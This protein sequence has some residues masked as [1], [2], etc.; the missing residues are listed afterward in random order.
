MTKVYFVGA[1][2]GAV[3]LITVRGMNLIK[4]ADVIIYAGSLVNPKLL[5]YNEKDADIYNSATMDL[6]EVMGVMIP[7]VKS[8]KNVV[9]L[10]TGDPSLYGAIGEQIRE[11]EKEGINYEV[12]PGVSAAFG[13]AAELACEMTLPDVSQTIIFTRM[14]GKTKVPEKESIEKLASH[15]A[16]MAIYLSGTMAEDLSSKLLEGGYKLS[17]P[18][19]VCHK[20]TWEDQIIVRTDVEHMSQV[21]NDND[22]K[23]TTLFLVGDSIGKDTD[24]ELS[25]LYASDFSTAFRKAKDE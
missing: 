2:C 19:A 6:N 13:A 21:V 8:G 4:E 17:T 12:V 22:I 3:D 16:T 1:G 5:E 15:N 9:R 24:F 11:L 25:R 23:N 18:V 14:E 10:H 20:V 7:A